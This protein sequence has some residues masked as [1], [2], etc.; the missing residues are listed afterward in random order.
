[1]RYPSG[2]RKVFDFDRMH[3]YLASSGMHLFFGD[4]DT[5]SAGLICSPAYG[6]GGRLPFL[7][8]DFTPPW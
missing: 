8:R 6:A 3:G 4:F 7:A 5:K 1:M 2:A